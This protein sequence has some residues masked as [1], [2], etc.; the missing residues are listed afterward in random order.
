MTE[1]KKDFRITLNIPH[2]LNDGD[3]G[4]KTLER[5]SAALKT[6]DRMP[7]FKLQYGNRTREGVRLDLI[8]EGPQGPV[9]EPVGQTLSKRSGYKGTSGCRV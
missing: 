9:D 4:M 8:F 5:I 3:E 2:A 6:N 7:E 1:P